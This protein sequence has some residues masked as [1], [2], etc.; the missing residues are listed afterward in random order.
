MQVITLT[1]D[2]MAYKYCVAVAQIPSALPVGAC[3]V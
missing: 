2:S 3:K 1:I